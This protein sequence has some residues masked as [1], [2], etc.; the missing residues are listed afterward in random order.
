MN[1]FLMTPKQAIKKLVEKTEFQEN[2]LELIQEG[3]NMNSQ[4]YKLYLDKEFTGL[5]FE[6]HTGM[7]GV[8][9]FCEKFQKYLKDLEIK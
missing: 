6:T 8:Q 2:R 1:E 9:D 3:S 7:K 4:M 5:K